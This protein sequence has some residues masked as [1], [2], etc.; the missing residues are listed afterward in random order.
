M[1]QHMSEFTLPVTASYMIY[2]TYALSMAMQ[3]IT[4]KLISKYEKQIE[5]LTNQCTMKSNECHMT[6][7]SVESNNLEIGR[8]KIELHRKLKWEV[9]VWITSVQYTFPP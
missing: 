4:S 6:W 3:T 2:D 8:L 1:F 9:L 5:E 7:S